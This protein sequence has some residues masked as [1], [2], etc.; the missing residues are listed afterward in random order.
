MLARGV[1]FHARSWHPALCAQYMLHEILTQRRH[2]I[3]TA[4]YFK[5]RM[6]GKQRASV[7]LYASIFC[8][9]HALCLAGNQLN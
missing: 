6:H 9:I 4:L 1:K 3:Q 8:T 5:K 7:K 2:R